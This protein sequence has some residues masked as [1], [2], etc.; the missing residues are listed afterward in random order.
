LRQDEL[1][2]LSIDRLRLVHELAKLTLQ[3]AQVAVHAE[4]R[5]L[6]EEMHHVTAENPALWGR[7]V[8]SQFDEDGIIER[9]FE[10]IGNGSTFIEIGCGNG[11]ENNT[12][13][14]L[15]KG[16]YGM[17]VDGSKENISAISQ[18][19]PK[20]KRLIVMHEFVNAENAV[21]LVKRFPFGIPDFLSLDIDGN[22][23]PVLQRLLSALSPKVICVEY[24]AKF[25]PPLSIAIKYDPRH[26]WVGDDYHGA[27][28]QAFVDALHG[29][30]LVA[31]NLVGANAFFVRK[32]LASGFHRYSPQ[33]LY[34][35]LRLHLLQMQSGHPASYRFL[36]D[37][38]KE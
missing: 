18:N 1:I 6:L 22:D 9:I 8:Y 36:A 24:N 4:I 33:E 25:K 13:F 12:H 11:L 20:S 14:L 28:L 31:C 16:W 10:V 27:S 37:A 35:P 26:V 7:K 29:Y 2:R 19:L 30:T 21:S 5:N 38:L 17:W 32:D 3:Q 23:L 34:Q 15:L